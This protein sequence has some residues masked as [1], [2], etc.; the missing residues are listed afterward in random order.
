MTSDDPVMAKIA[1]SDVYSNVFFSWVVEDSGDLGIGF[2]MYRGHAMILQRAEF[3][4]KMKAVV[5]HARLT[6]RP[7]YLLNYR[8]E[9]VPVGAKP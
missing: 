4:R 1:P 8:I 9:F 3:E 6:G 5:M 7:E 2:S